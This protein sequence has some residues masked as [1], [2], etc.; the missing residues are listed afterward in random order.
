MLPSTSSFRTDRNRNP[1]A[2]TIDIAK[3]GGLVENTD[4][5]TGDPFEAGGRTYF[6]AKLLGDPVA[7]T[8]KVID[9]IGFYTHAGGERWAY[10]GMPQFIWEALTPDQKRDVVGEMYK[11]EGG[12]EMRGLFPR[13]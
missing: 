3:E 7:L 10:I 8:I 9:A 12:T 2:F 6:T 13:L 1:T 11:R 4:Y 5:V